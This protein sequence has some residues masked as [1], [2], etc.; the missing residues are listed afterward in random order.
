[1][2]RIQVIGAPGAGKSTLAKKVSEVT[3]YKLIDL[4]MNFHLPGWQMRETEEFR[5]IIQSKIAGVDNWIL[6]GDYYSKLGSEILEQVDT[7]VWMN[8]P[9]LY[10]QSR[11]IRR[12]LKRII[13]KELLWGVNRESTKGAY[14]LFKFAIRKHRELEEQVQE[15]WI[16]NDKVK[17]IELKSKRDAEKYIR[18]LKDAT[19]S[20]Q[21][22]P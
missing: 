15:R 20:F 21:L 7:V 14:G 9:L 2:K 5:Q 1:M 16:N 13:T 3:G 11:L 10:S 18:Q 4:D 17:V 12:S 6:D 8:T 19:G 22:R